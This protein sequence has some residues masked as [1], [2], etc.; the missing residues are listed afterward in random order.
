[1]PIEKP[2]VEAGA[3]PYCHA[4]RHNLNHNHTSILFCQ[5]E[6]KRTRFEQGDWF[7]LIWFL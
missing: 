7:P 5:L 3:H 4:N 2:L 1:M 6:A